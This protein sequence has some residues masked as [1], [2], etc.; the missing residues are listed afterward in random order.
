ML[1]KLMMKYVGKALLHVGND[2]TYVVRV[3]Q[4]DERRRRRGG[5]GSSYGQRLKLAE[6]TSPWRQFYHCID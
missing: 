4:Y 6:G 5:V 1:V 2:K 3:A